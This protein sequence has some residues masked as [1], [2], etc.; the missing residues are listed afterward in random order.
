MKKLN[1]VIL[2]IIFQE[3]SPYFLNKS[4]QSHLYECVQNVVFNL[5]S[6]I[7]VIGNGDVKH[8]LLFK[9]VYETSRYKIGNRDFSQATKFIQ[10]DIYIIA[11]NTYDGLKNKLQNLTFDIYFNPSALTIVVLESSVLNDI[12]V[13]FKQ[14]YSFNIF[15]VSVITQFLKS[16]VPSIVLPDHTKC[17]FCDITKEMLIFINC[18]EINNKFNVEVL[19]SKI[20]YVSNAISLHSYNTTIMLEKHAPFAFFKIKDSIDTEEGYEG[21]FLNKIKNRYNVKYVENIHNEIIG[22][23]IHNV[24]SVILR[25]VFYGEYDGVVGG[26]ILS[27][28]RKQALDFVYPHL[29]DYFVVIIP[30]SPIIERWKST[31]YSFSITVWILISIVTLL[32]SIFALILNI[33]I[34]QRDKCGV[35][36]SVLGYFFGNSHQIRSNSNTRIALISWSI[37]TWLLCSYFQSKLSSV[38]TRPAHQSQIGSLDD[39]S[40]QRYTLYINR[41]S[42]WF[43]ENTFGKKPSEVFTD[44]KICN[45]MLE[46]LHHVSMGGKRVT[47]SSNL[48]FLYYESSF[49]D[50]YGEQKLYKL[51]KPYFSFWFSIYMRRGHPLVKSMRSLE[52]SIIESGL[53]GKSI[54]DLHFN[55]SVKKHFYK[56]NK[57]NSI[58]YKDM[59]GIY[60]ILLIGWLLSTIIFILELVNHKLKYHIY[61]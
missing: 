7:M 19:N 32:F 40:E 53:L 28:E 50:E 12:S 14:L 5:N 48:H 8:D 3:S 13:V 21:I 26:L 16:D 34:K 17:K 36:V 33:F 56:N 20:K 55:I 27:A 57:I 18:N 46:C 59:E 54:L 24:S 2:F 15:N 41:A 10:S 29:F 25:R 37:F 45:N 42:Y 1:I 47:I 38:F 11:T 61:R 31:L 43:I 44:I 6:D 35:F 30:R 23:N 51:P 9:I 49:R 52:M 58:S 39:I 4:Q 22:S 60:Y